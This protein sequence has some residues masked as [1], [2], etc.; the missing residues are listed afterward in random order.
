MQIAQFFVDLRR[1]L[2]LT[3]PQIAAYLRVSVDCIE[4]LESGR[5]ELLP[6]RRETAQFIL[7]YASLA[8]IDGRPLLNA[9]GG[10]VAK[11]ERYSALGNSPA[12]AAQTTMADRGGRT[13][14][15]AGSALANGAM[16]L[17]KDA[18][19]QVRRR[20]DRAVYA[21]SLPLGLLLIGLNS[22]SIAQVSRPFSLSV[23]W[24]SGYFQEHFGRVQGG[25]RYIEVDDPRSRRADLLPVKGGS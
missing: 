19:N 8:Q 20:P 14:R 9:I 2:R 21:L 18:M 17:P 3:L 22:G 10:L 15:R 13:L 12:A 4:H 6:Q 1:G 25:L 11:L 5:V 7:D 23:E 24:L 16:R